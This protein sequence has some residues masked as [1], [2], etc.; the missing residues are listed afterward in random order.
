MGVYF[1]KLIINHFGGTVALSEGPGGADPK[2]L[3][4]RG[5]TNVAV[6]N[7]SLNPDDRSGPSGRHHHGHSRPRR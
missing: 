1:N 2:T 7:A 5:T 6:V 4:V 3:I